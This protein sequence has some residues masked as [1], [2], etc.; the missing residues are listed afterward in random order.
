MQAKNTLSCGAAEKPCL[1]F[2]HRRSNL[3]PT[4]NANTFSTVETHLVS[5]LTF[6]SAQNT[7]RNNQG[8]RSIDSIII[9]IGLK[10]HN[11]SCKCHFRESPRQTRLAPSE[12]SINNARE[13]CNRSQPNTRSLIDFLTN[14]AASRYITVVMPY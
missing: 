12:G 8:Q 5:P 10:N 9:I 3:N 2:N 14:K 13:S 7:C 11:P 4:L 6:S 1:I